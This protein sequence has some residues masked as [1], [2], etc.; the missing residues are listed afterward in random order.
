MMCCSELGI[1]YFNISLCTDLPHKNSW[2]SSDYFTWASY[3]VSLKVEGKNDFPGRTV[4]FCLS[5]STVSVATLFLPS[6][7]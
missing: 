7:L 6:P 4:D 1:M 5:V 3:V 2:T